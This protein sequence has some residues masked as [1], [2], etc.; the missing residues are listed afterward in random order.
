VSIYSEEKARKL[1]LKRARKFEVLFREKTFDTIM[2]AVEVKPQR[3]DLFDKA[4]IDAGLV[5]VEANWLWGY[6]QHSN[7]DLWDPVP[8]AP[9][10]TGW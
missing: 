9:A 1:A 5:Q 2:N 4:C 3:R 7:K 10:Y 8:E 6:L